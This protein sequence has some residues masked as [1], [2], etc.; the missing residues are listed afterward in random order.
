MT[1]VI[2]RAAITRGEGGGV[3][4]DPMVVRELILWLLTNTRTSSRGWSQRGG[5]GIIARGT[6]SVMHG[7]HHLTIII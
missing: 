5:S 3:H 2:V 7:S 6:G 4:I 1:V